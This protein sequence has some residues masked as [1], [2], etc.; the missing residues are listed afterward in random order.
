MKNFITILLF[1]FVVLNNNTIRTQSKQFSLDEVTTIL[2]DGV[3][4]LFIEESEDNVAELI[5]DPLLENHI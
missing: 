5:Y 1:L 3:D 4:E 2:I